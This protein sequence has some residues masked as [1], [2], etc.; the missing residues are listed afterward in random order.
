[1][2]NKIKKLIKKIRALEPEDLEALTY[3]FVGLIVANVMVLHW[4][5]KMQRLSNL[6]LIFL[7]GGLV[8]VQILS[9]QQKKK[10]NQPKVEAYS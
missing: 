9:P 2:L 5:F 10:P 8:L 3:I 1:M 7:I 6:I 4:Y